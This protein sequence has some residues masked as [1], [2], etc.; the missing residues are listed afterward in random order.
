MAQAAKR[1]RVT[2]V[3]RHMR[4]GN[5]G[6]FPICDREG[7]AVGAISEPAELALAPVRRKKFRARSKTRVSKISEPRV[8]RSAAPTTTCGAP[9]I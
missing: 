3:A 2:K 7:R 8:R 6:F 4:D 1:A 9:T 5:V